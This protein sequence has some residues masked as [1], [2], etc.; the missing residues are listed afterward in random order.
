MNLTVATFLALGG[1]FIVGGSLWF[2]L[3]ERRERREE[4]EE[5]LR[6]EKQ[7]T[8]DDTKGTQ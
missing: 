5:Q 8:N 7:R 2:W 3:D 1:L 6:R 4:R